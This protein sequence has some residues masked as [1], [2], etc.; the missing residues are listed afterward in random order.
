MFKFCQR[1]KNL[2]CLQLIRS[3]HFSF[4][5]FEFIDEVG[6]R[7]RIEGRIRKKMLEMVANRKKNMNISLINLHY[8]IVK[9]Y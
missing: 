8:G 7:N 1:R 5:P 4:S 3:S 9:L 2:Q 6:K